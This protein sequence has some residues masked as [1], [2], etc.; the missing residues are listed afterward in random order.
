MTDAADI[1]ATRVAEADLLGLV[2]SRLCHDLISP[3]GAIGNGVELLTEMGGA[4]ADGPELRLIA[5]S[6]DNLSATLQFL[7]IAFGAAPVG[8]RQGLP[9]LQ[10]VARA[11]FAHQRPSLDW[12]DLPGE[13]TRRAARLRLNLLQAAASCLPRGGEVRVVERPDGGFEVTASG[14][15]LAAPESAESWLSG[16]VHAPRPQPREVHWVLA[17]RHAREAGASV[18]LVRGEARLTLA[19]APPR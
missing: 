19:A 15:G 8:E 6:A 14:A 18:E 12:P 5:A 9:A 2:A 10:R 11:W 13:T 7:R 1:A 4:A 16:D 3:A 17:G